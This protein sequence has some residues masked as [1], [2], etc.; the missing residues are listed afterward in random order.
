MNQQISIIVPCYNQAQYLS[1]ALQSVLEQTYTNWECIIVN[2]GS[3]DDTEQI[4]KRWLEKDYRFKYV[5]KENGG[6]SSARNAGLDLSIGDYIQFLDSDDVLNKFKLEKSINSINENNA[7]LVVSNF[8]MFTTEFTTTS[9][10]YCVLKKE[11]LNY[12]SILY[13]WDV[14]FSIPIHC[15][16]FKQCFFN[17]FRF[18]LEL[19]AKEDWIMW[20]SIFQ[21]NPNCVFLNE[22]LVL[23]R[24]HCSSM[25]K[26]LDLMQENLLKAL[27]YLKNHLNIVDF[28][29]LFI[30]K[31]KAMYLQITTLETEIK[32]HKN[33][34][35]VLKNSNTFKLAIKIVAFLK[36]IGFVGFLKFIKKKPYNLC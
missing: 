32:F 14:L 34:L 4:A 22:T 27:I 26:D 16:L 7:K 25:T 24:I 10:P 33:K 19:K 3:P 6:L 35:S 20:I 11:Y 1:E 21:T 28:E 13:D 29:Q 2:D 17:N 23:Y 8:E 36:V 30:C 12:K 31:F 5:Y 18:P 9:K 15:G